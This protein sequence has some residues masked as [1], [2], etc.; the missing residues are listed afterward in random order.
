MR[1]WPKISADSASVSSANS[2]AS[3]TGF[4]LSRNGLLA[5][6]WHVVADAKNISVVFPGRTSAV[7]AEIVVKDAVNDLAVLRVIDAVKLTATCPDLRSS[8]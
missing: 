8:D 7:S 5:E 6:N 1:V 3:G 4:L 2:S